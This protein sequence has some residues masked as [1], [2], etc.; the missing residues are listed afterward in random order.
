M[1]PCDL[2]TL[3][4]SSLQS[5]A[6]S[7]GIKANQKSSVIIRSLEEIKEETK[8]SQIDSHEKVVEKVEEN[9]KV[10]DVRKPKEIQ[11]HIPSPTPIVHMVNSTQSTDSDKG[12]FLSPNTLRL[13]RRVVSSSATGGEEGEEVDQVVRANAMV[14]EGLGGI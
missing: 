13:V 6:K 3:S 4:R 14:F 1:I 5:L 7:Y 11:V 9:V 2:S 8:S 12:A 10:E